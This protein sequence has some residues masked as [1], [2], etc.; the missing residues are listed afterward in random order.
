[1][2]GAK[3]LVRWAFHRL[4][5]AFPYDSGRERMH[6]G[7]REKGFWS[8]CKLRAYSL[9]PRVSDDLVCVTTSQMA[10][11]HS[12]SRCILPSIM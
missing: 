12:R 5:H 9:A 6:L 8:R 1:M 7:T 11:G 2:S 3:R 10:E 4:F